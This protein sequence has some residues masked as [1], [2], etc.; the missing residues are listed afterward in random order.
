[1]AIEMPNTLVMAN[2]SNQRRRDRNAN[3]M[4]TWQ[5]SSNCLEMLVL[6]LV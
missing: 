1:M 4:P 5:L 3:A 2:V 6:E